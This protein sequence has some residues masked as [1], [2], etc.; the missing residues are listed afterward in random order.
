[1]IEEK[2]YCRHEESLGRGMDIWESLQSPRHS[3]R[4][5]E[6][7]E[8]GEG[9][10]RRPRAQEGKRVDKKGLDDENG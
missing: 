2:V 1:M 7:K 10:A 3:A 8:R 5:C 4:A 6:E 9:K